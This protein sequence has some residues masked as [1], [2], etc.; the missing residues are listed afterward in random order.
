[1]TMEFEHID[2]S[3]GEAPAELLSH[4]QGEARLQ[5]FPSPFPDGPAVFAVHFRPGGRT[6]PHTH[7]FGQ[8]LQVTSGKGIIGSEDGRRVVGPGDVV[9]V[10]PDEW[11]WHGATPDSPMTH[12]TVQMSGPDSVNWDVDER[13][14]AR[15]YGG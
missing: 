11:H 15:D 9:A 13:D 10:M 5:P 7:R 4:F 14:W 6:M 8:V 2:D 3:R 12:F 1:M